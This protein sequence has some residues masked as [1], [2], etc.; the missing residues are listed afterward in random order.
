MLNTLTSFCSYD[1]IR[2]HRCKQFIFGYPLHTSSAR[3]GRVRG[4]RS[5]G[6][7][8]QTLGLV[9]CLQLINEQNCSLPNLVRLEPKSGP[10]WDWKMERLSTG[11]TPFFPSD[12]TALHLLILYF[13]L[14]RWPRSLIRQP[15]TDAG[16]E[17]LFSL[18]LLSWCAPVVVIIVIIVVVVIIVFCSLRISWHFYGCYKLMCTHMFKHS[19]FAL[20]FLLTSL[21]GFCVRRCRLDCM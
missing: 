18:Y 10:W 7:G 15:W 17:I 19:I 21:R 13:C 8:S 16:R 12:P 3:T 4:S 11:P 14:E 5:S 2:K 9:V 1:N 6:H 20:V